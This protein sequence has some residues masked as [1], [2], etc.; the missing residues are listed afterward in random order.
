MRP[1][2]YIPE[3]FLPGVHGPVDGRASMRPGFY[4]PECRA[5]PARLDGVGERFNEAGILHPGMRRPGSE[6]SAVELASMRPGFYIP[7]CAGPAAQ[8]IDGRALQ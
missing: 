3:C 4:I 5:N 6:L 7:E 8:E 1:G 2:F